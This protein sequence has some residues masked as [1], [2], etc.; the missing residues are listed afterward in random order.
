[1]KFGPTLF[2]AA[3]LVATM[4]ASSKAEMLLSIDVAGDQLVRIDTDTG[5]VAPVGPL[6]VDATPHVELAVSG[7]VLYMLD[8]GQ[9]P[10]LYAINHTTGEATLQAT[11]A[12]S[13]AEGPG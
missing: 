6:G 8:S 12:T 1:M 13:L 7:G 5:S 9:S 11:V 2:I 4:N 3:V 10:R